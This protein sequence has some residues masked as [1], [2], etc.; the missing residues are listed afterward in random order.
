MD[1]VGNGIRHASDP[2][3]MLGSVTVSGNIS[4]Q[5]ITLND[6]STVTPVTPDWVQAKPADGAA[7]VVWGS[8]EDQDGAQIADYYVVEYSSSSTF[9][10]STTKTVAASDNNFLIVGGLTNTQTYYFRVSA[11]V[12]DTISSPTD[13]S[14]PVIVGTPPGGYT[15]TVPVTMTGFSSPGPLYLVL[16]GDSGTIFFNKISSP[17]TGT[18]YVYGVQNGTYHVHAFVDMDNDGILDAGDITY[19]GDWFLATVNGGAATSPAITLNSTDTFAVVK[20]RHISSVSLAMYILN[21]RIRG[22]LKQPVSVTLTGGPVAISYPIDIGL[23]LQDGDFNYWFSPPT[24]PSVSDTYT[25]TVG[26]SDGSPDTNVQVQVTGVLDTFPSPLAPV[27]SIA[28]PGSTT[29]TFTWL[30]PSP[31]PSGYYSYTLGLYSENGEVWDTNS[32]PS[33]Q[34]QAAFNFDGNANVPALSVGTDYFWSIAAQDSYGNWAGVQSPFI[35]TSA[36]ISL[37]GSVLASNDQPISGVTVALDGDPSISTTTA[38]DGTFTLSGLPSGLPFALKATKS[39]YLPAYSDIIN[40]TSDIDLPVPLLLFTGTEVESW[41]VTSGNGSIVGRVWDLN[42]GAAVGGAVVTAASTLYPGK[43]YSV[44]YFDG[45]GFGGSSTYD[46]GMVYVLNVYDGDTVTL[47]AAKEGYSFTDK[48]VPVH[49]DAVSESL[50]YCA[51]GISFSGYVTNSSGAPMPGASVEMVG[52]PAVSTTTD[53]SGA[54]TLSG[55]PAGTDFSMKISKT[56]HVPVYTCTINSDSDI[57]DP[58][59]AIL[60]TQAEASGWGVTSENGVIAVHAVDAAN[61]SSFLSGAVATATSAN[62]PDTPY[63]VTYSYGGSSTSSDGL[64]FVLNVDA[65]DTVTLHTTKD[66]WIFSDVVFTVQ[67]DSVS[68]GLLKGVQQKVRIK[69]TTKYFSTLQSAFDDPDSSSVNPVQALVDEF[70]ESLALNQNKT[71]TLQGGFDSGFTSN[72][73]LTSLQGTLTIQNGS[74]TVENLVIK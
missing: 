74:L 73:G 42:G 36:T 2:V 16:T 40:T 65:G 21:F 56:G 57:L 30:P 48:S 8:P 70:S 68:E 23:S 51:R 66:G 6:P 24:R 29:P 43:Y 7:F 64:V 12:G 22:G 62:H 5:N 60:Y 45:S 59:P 18:Y 11:K 26:Y 31:A 4:S 53:D 33:T 25:F 17:T 37:T 28:G 14:G 20:T 63:A 47:H 61:F 1:T 55:L 15:V 39:G 46:N 9:T 27:G 44:T 41:G 52:N 10:G 50:I 49:G 35:I 19:D 13:S 3:C 32:I 72:S 58:V 71:V 38:A 34:T 54:Y 67:G 69:N